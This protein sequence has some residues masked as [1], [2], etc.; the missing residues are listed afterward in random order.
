MTQQQKDARFFKDAKLFTAGEICRKLKKEIQRMKM[1][2]H[3][4]NHQII[5]SIEAFLKANIDT[6]EKILKYSRHY[7]DKP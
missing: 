7:Q 4:D 2:G 3:Y 6:E 1:Q 5:Q